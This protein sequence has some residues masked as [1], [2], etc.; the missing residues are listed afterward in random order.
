VD[1]TEQYTPQSGQITGILKQMGDTMTSDLEELVA[2]EEA[3]KK[4]FAEMQTAK[5]GEVAAASTAIEAKT[6]RSGE[7]AV[8]IV[9]AKNDVANAERELTDL[10]AFLANLSVECDN[11]KKEHGTRTTDRNNELIAIGEAIK[12]LNDDDALDMFKKTLPSPGKSF[13]QVSRMRD[14]T[15]KALQ[16]ISNAAI[17]SHNPM[18]GMIQQMLRSHGVSFAKVIKM[19]TDM[20]QVLDNEQADDDKTQGF[21]NEELDAKNAA[22]AD[23]KSKISDLSAAVDDGKAQM[24]TLQS[25]LENLAAKNKELFAAMKDASEAREAEK[26][27]FIQQRSEFETAKALI[28]KA[29]NKLNKYYNPA[30]YKPPPKAEQTEEERIYENLSFLQLP[31]APE[32]W[33][34]ERK[35]QGQASSGVIALMDTLVKDIDLQMKDAV[36]EEETSQRDYDTL[37]K[38]SKDAVAANE[39]SKT[40]KEGQLANTEASVHEAENGRR[41]TNDEL[42][43][44]KQDLV[45][46][47]ANCDFILQNY[48]FRKEARAN[49]K[50]A[51][52]NAKA[53]LSGAN[54]AFIQIKGEPEEV[55]YQK[56][57]PFGKE[58]TAHELTKHAANTQDTLVDAVENAEVAEI[59][60]TVFRA[61]TRLRA[62]TIK[63]F[64]TIARLETQAIDEYNDNHHYRAE[65]P[66]E[67]IGSGEPH[68]SEDKYT[69]FHN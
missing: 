37:M 47:H 4:A 49:E 36:N 6:Q 11:K 19:I 5:E 31:K 22:E 20:V 50:N 10:E 42:S 46:L 44:I 7:V 16:L 25:E 29:K 62:A 39:R 9:E 8:A 53:I 40:E 56:I 2:T 12:I 23:A 33:E 13:L 15:A 55:N 60:R 3:A 43:A 65:N 27:E 67:Y 66:L 64:D 17:H 26:K 32:T 45:Q 1:N 35:N 48:D 57:E 51:L 30:L 63:E 54:Y 14:T 58:D 18:L 38:D 69:S 41:N 24:S 34:G 21:C 28:A 61:L 59:K 52:N 68:V